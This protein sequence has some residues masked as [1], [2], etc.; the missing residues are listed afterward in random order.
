MGFLKKPENVRWWKNGETIFP[1]LP[2]FFFE[3]IHINR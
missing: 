2:L 1:P 3:K